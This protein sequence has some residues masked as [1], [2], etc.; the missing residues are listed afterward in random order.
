MKTTAKILSS[1]GILLF[2][3]GCMP[4]RPG[5]PIMWNGYFSQIIFGVML[6][7]FVIVLM[8][9]IAGSNKDTAN[10]HTQKELQDISAKLDEIKKDLNEIKEWMRNK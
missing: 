7:L 3:S 8:K 4:G 9:L 2:L 5:M 6:L 10:G 1:S